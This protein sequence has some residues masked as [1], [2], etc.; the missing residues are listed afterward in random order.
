MQ[1]KYLIISL[2]CLILVANVS[3]Q[4]QVEWQPDY[5]VSL[6]DFQGT[7]PRM[8]EDQVQRFRFACSMGFNYAMSTYEFMFTKNFNKYVTTYFVPSTSWIEPGDRTNLLVGMA[9]LNFDLTELYARKFRKRVYENKGTFS[10]GDFAQR[11]F[12]MIN[13]EY[14]ERSAQIE[15]DIMSVEHTAAKLNEWLTTIRQEIDE[16]AE[17]CKTCKIKKKK[18]K[19]RVNKE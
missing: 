2:F 10:S 12:D 11:E 19:D 5:K 7:P 3:A 8:A 4:I 9:Q 6:E 17:F 15:S 14:N 1:F 18:K 16:L 13:N